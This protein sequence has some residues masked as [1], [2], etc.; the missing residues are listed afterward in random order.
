VSFLWCCWDQGREVWGGGADAMQRGGPPANWVGA[1]R[2]RRLASL[3]QFIVAVP[4]VRCSCAL[5]KNP[6]PFPPGIPC[7]C[8][9][10]CCSSVAHARQL[11]LSDLL[12]S[13][14]HTPLKL[15]PEDHTLWAA[16]RQRQQQ[17]QRRAAAAAPGGSTVSSSSSRPG[18]AAAK[19]A[20]GGTKAKAA[21]KVPPSSQAA[22]T[23]AAAADASADSSSTAAAA[24]AAVAAPP[25]YDASTLAAPHHPHHRRDAYQ[26]L[27]ELVY[28]SPYIDPDYVLSKLHQVREVAW[29]V[30]GVGGGGERGGGR[31]R[32]HP[33]P[34]CGVLA[35][36]CLTIERSRL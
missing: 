18:R 33:K 15:F 8:C 24:A 11:S 34:K 29:C 23:E 7:W 14:P 1:A 21:G 25:K 16:P 35:S 17:Q 30:C 20:V 3:P 31:R 6:Q 13:R 36:V 5:P 4:L 28:A 9:W 2:R 19:G 27:R 32:Q 26:R 10:C 22:D 12:V